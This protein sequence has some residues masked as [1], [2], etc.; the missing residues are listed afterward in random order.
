MEEL[1]E[2]LKTAD[3]VVTEEPFGFAFHFCDT[4]Q[5]QTFE[6]Q[7]RTA[8]KTVTGTIPSTSTG[9]GDGYVIFNFE[10]ANRP[11]DPETQNAIVGGLE[12]A[13]KIDFPEE[14]INHL[15]DWHHDPQKPTR[16]YGECELV[17]SSASKSFDSNGFK[18]I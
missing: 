5:L 18:P 9:G 17:V 12:D 1:K 13:L 11:L 3:Y 14:R 15:N 7:L 10:H 8:M 16:I 2:A 4:E 6:D